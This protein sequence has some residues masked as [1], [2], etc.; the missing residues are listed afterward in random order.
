MTKKVAHKDAQDYGKWDRDAEG[1]SKWK[2]FEIDLML[3]PSINRRVYTNASR[4]KGI[5]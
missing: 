3:K 2:N 5:A 1:Q 4:N